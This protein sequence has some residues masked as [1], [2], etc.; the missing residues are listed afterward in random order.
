MVPTII[1]NGSID[2]GDNSCQKYIGLSMVANMV[3]LGKMCKKFML[4]KQVELLLFCNSTKRK[5][6][7][8]QRWG[9]L[10][11]HGR[12]VR[13]SVYLYE[14]PYDIR[15]TVPE[16]NVA[17]GYVSIVFARLTYGGCV[18]Q[19]TPGG[20]TLPFI[21]RVA[22]VISWYHIYIIRLHRLSELQY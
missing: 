7:W 10:A 2:C 19:C 11:R 9:H 20:Q 3:P 4:E 14:T 22:L 18:Y 16:L 13:W 5:R 12:N 1:R 6:H 17:P 15:I 8:L 21:I